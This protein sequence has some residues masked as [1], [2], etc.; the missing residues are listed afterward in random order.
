MRLIHDPEYL[1]ID[2][3][4]QL[5][6]LHAK[7][8]TVSKQLQFVKYLAGN[9]GDSMEH[10]ARCSMLLALLCPRFTRFVMHG[11]LRK[12]FNRCIRKAVKTEPFVN[13]AD[14][15]GRLAF[16]DIGENSIKFKA[17]PLAAY[18]KRN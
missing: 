15:L 7:Y 14:R 8:G 4:I 6:N 10:Y 3:R 16:N 2:P 9:S 17:K 18:A 11:W 5:E 12:P 1:Q 13:Y